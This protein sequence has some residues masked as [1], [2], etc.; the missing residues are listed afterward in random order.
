MHVVFDDNLLPRKDSCDDDDVGILQSNGGEPSSKVD[1]IPTKEEA[2]N[3]PLEALKDMTLEEREVAY[4]RELNYVKDGEILG[5]PSKGVT[6]RAS[7]K[8]TC[9]H[10][11]FISCIE[12][13]IIK[14]ALNDDYWILAMG[15]DI[16]LRLDDK[17]DVSARD[18]GSGLS[19]LSRLVQISAERLAE[20]LAYV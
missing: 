19:R 3:P 12:P 10:V 7:L 4:P 1:E 17:G 16:L 6:T 5:D 18:N 20:L 14:E 2:Q 15:F 13:K 8:N 9:H 11:A